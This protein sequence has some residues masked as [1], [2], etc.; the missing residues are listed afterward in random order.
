MCLSVH[1]FAS[2]QKGKQKTKKQANKILISCTCNSDYWFLHG[3]FIVVRGIWWPAMATILSLSL[4][5]SL[6]ISLSISL[7]PSLSLSLS[8]SLSLTLPLSLCLPL[9]LPPP[10]LTHAHSINYLIPA[11]VVKTQKIRL[12]LL[13]ILHQ[14]QVLPRSPSS[15][16]PSP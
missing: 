5:L 3:L 14:C 7:P 2:V 15:S 12:K 16:T 1:H 11:F 6:S 9:P 10:P 13:S 4:S 8:F